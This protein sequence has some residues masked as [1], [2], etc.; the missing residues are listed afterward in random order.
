MTFS[1]SYKKGISHL[2][3]L[4]DLQLNN[5]LITRIEGLS[6]LTGIQ[7]LD[8]SHNPIQDYAPL[9]SLLKLQVST[10]IVLKKIDSK[11]QWKFNKITSSVSANEIAIGIVHKSQ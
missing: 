10:L 7:E 6:G 3:V 4:S 8:L 9:K 1:D 2:R 11:S 5:N